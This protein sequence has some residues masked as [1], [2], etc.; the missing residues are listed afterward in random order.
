MYTLDKIKS[1]EIFSLRYVEQFWIV[2]KK[3]LNES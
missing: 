3:Q 2:M 1:A